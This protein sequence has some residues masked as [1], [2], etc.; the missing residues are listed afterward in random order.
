[1]SIMKKVYGWNVSSNDSQNYVDFCNKIL[2]NEEL[3]SKFKSNYEYNSILE[4]VD[5]K[6]GEEYFNY[7]KE[8]GEK[9][10]L[11]NFDKFVE[12]DLIGCPRQY[13]YE[14][15]KISPT[16]LR[17]IKN[18]LDL[19]AICNQE[20]I[21]KIVEIGG[22]YGGLCKTLSVLCDYDEYIN[23]DLP[24]IVK[25][26]KKYLS[27]FSKLQS[28]TKF[29]P[30]NELDDIFDIDILISNYCLSELNFEKQLEYYKKVIKNSKIVYITYNFMIENC[31][32][33]YNMLV[34]QLKNDGYKFDEN[35]FDFGC[36][37]NKIIVA[38]K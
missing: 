32:N 9:I 19:S 5:Q 4:H 37:T 12:N 22:G 1:M 31:E 15:K 33:N 7:I 24:D 8:V 17:Y 25:F 34:S 14:G 2:E 23:I 20:K 35:Y 26:Q 13:Y 18:A 28:K 29:I 38:K 10:Y 27:N 21:S 11:D 30:C 6:L 16:T 3:F 36:S